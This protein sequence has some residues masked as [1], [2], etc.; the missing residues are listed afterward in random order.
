M[1]E[2][3]SIKNTWNANRGFIS[4]TLRNFFISSIFIASGE[5]EI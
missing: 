1:R 3:F 4:Q 5:S 2:I